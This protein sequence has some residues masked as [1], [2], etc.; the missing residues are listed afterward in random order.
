MNIRKQSPAINSILFFCL[1]FCG[2]VYADSYDPATA[3]I[4][5]Q[6]TNS[7]VLRHLASI[8]WYSDSMNS[9]VTDA[10]MQEMINHIK[11]D[12]YSGITFD[13]SVNV[14]ADGTVLNSYINS[15]LLTQI[16]YA[17]SIGLTVDTKIHW[18]ADGS[19]GNLADEVD[20]PTGF[21]VYTFLY[22]VDAYFKIF[23]P[24]A[25]AHGVTMQYLGT[26]NNNVT[27]TQYLPQW[28]Q[29]VSDIRASY[30]GQISYDGNFLGALSNSFN[31][32]AIWGLVDKIGLSFYPTLSQT[33]VTDLP[34]IISL[35]KQANNALANPTNKSWMTPYPSIVDKIKSLNKQYGKQVVLGEVNYQPVADNLHGYMDVSTLISNN[36]PPNYDS[37]TLAYQAL[38]NVL[39]NDLKG[40]VVGETMCG[41]ESWLLSWI[42]R[43]PYNSW[44]PY[45]QLTG[46]TTEQALNN[47]FA[48]QTKGLLLTSSITYGGGTYTGGNGI[49]TVVYAGNSSN[50]TVSQTTSGLTVTD[51]VDV[52]GI[53]TLVNIQ[54]LQFA[55]TMKSVGAGIVTSIDSYNSLTNQLTIPLVS[56]GT[57][58]YQKVVVTLGKVISVGTAPANIAYDSYNGATGQLT[59][60]VVTVGSVTYYN[61]V[62]YIVDVVSVG[63]KL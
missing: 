31:Q 62:S 29:I 52:K 8:A 39:Y 16:D 5:S 46:T 58:K 10:Q 12:G 32:I 49:N 56:V 34:Q 36:T 20:P 43:S 54:Y 26:E 57:D 9:G 11:A 45:A 27:T 55:D 17:K 15:R 59:I 1:A 2:S 51:N 14:A 7:N 30:S 24:I 60:P 44:I 28:T 35:F 19:F 4:T 48:Q 50:Y 33:P 21:N 18:S 41:Y 61:V 37:A 47:I 25:E 13:Y 40:I 22:G 53:D 6:A 23:S 38:F 3:Q 63:G 42:N